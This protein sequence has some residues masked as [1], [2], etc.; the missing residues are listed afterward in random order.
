MADQNPTTVMEP[1]T[2]YPNEVPT[3]RNATMVEQI[4]QENAGP[5]PK[6]SYARSMSQ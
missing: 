5:S 1:Q 6:T 3:K 4:R 2:E